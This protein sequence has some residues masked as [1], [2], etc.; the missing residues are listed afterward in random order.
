MKMLLEAGLTTW[1]LSTTIARS[2]AC[3]PLRTWVARRSTFLY[4]GISCQYCLSHWIAV[5]ILASY[6]LAPTVTGYLVTW[7]TLVAGSALIGKI[8]ERLN[9]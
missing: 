5:A 8:L 6:V 3:D 2:R 7:G 1:V 9:K 4:E